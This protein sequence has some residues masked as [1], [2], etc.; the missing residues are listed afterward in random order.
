MTHLVL[1]QG[2]TYENVSLNFIDALYNIVKSNTLDSSSYLKGNL[3]TTKAYDDAVTYLTDKYSQLHI[4]VTGKSYI[5]YEDPN[6]NDIIKN[7]SIAGGDG[8]GV[9]KNQTRI[10]SLTDFW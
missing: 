9:D 5:R 3:R 10:Y 4:D 7:I 8:T 1:D 2:N 6:F